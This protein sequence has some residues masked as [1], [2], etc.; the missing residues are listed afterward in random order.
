M[1]LS[2]A[3]THPAQAEGPG[4][5]LA[6]A[7]AGALN[8]RG[9]TSKG[10]ELTDSVHSHEDDTEALHKVIFWPCTACASAMPGGCVR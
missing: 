7:A 8:G 10:A 9:T 1:A 4:N 5:K 2:L 6:A 3:N